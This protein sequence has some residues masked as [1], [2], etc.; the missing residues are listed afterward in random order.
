ME[1]HVQHLQRKI[2]QAAPAGTPAG[3]KAGTQN[4]R[5]GAAIVGATSPDGGTYTNTPPVS[6]SQKLTGAD[7]TF[8]SA[9]VLSKLTQFDQDSGTK[10]D[11]TR[12]GATTAIAAAVATEGQAG[13]EKF[14]GKIGQYLDDIQDPQAASQAK[15]IQ[16]K[17]KDGTATYGDLGKLGDLSAKA[18]GTSEAGIEFPD[19]LDMFDEMG[20]SRK[21]PDNGRMP[22]F[23]PGEVMPSLVDLDG[24]GSGDHFVLFGQNQEGDNFVYDPM[25]K[26]NGKQLIQP[27]KFDEVIPFFSYGTNALNFM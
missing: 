16:K 7:G 20:I 1:L 25:P 14:A 6:D 17:V 27:G 13:L 9:E 3:T 8:R 4:G 19:L 26:S 22:T 5:G 10:L 18:F 21:T 24:D 23:G 2:S 15:A 12:C 11:S